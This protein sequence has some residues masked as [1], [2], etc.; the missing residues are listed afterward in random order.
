MEIDEEGR[1]SAEEIAEQIV[2]VTGEEEER[3]KEISRN[4]DQ[5][6]EELE[7][8][9]KSSEP[10]EKLRMVL[11]EVEE[12]ERREVIDES[13]KEQDELEDSHFGEIR[14]QE[15]YDRAI[16]HHSDLRLRKSY[17]K[18][19]G[20][21]SEYFERLDY[22]DEVEKPSIVEEIENRELRRI[23][24]TVHDGPPEVGIESMEDVDNLLEKYPE[25]RDQSGFD[26]KHRRCKVYFEAK[27]E[28]SANRDNLAEEDGVSHTFIGY[29]RNG[30][31][32]NLMQR[33]HDYEERRIIG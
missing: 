30:I 3:R 23:H 12:Q 18:D 17:E 16:E 22:G 19:E 13:T 33:L 31:E 28:H 10:T 24:E 11:E 4:L 21:A 27:D 1:I 2:R 32:P 14:T 29:C 5:A 20:K 9:E 26:E 6:L 25:E 15:E 8:V 7:K